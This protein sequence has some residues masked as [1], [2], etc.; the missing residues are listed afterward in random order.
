MNIEVIVGNTRAIRAL[1]IISCRADTKHFFRGVIT[2]NMQTDH[3][4]SADYMLKTLVILDEN[5]LMIFFLNLVS[6]YYQN[7]HQ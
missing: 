2:N 7:R 1:W 5:I 4:E 6:N 3:Q